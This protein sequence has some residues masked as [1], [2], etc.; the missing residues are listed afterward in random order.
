MSLSIDVNVAPC[1]TPPNYTYNIVM[2][3]SYKA[4]NQLETWDD[5]SAACA[6]E[7]ATLIE[8]YTV[9]DHQVLI[10]MFSKHKPLKGIQKHKIVS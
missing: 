2:D 1:N 4:V 3:I 10:D 6:T 7:G 5:A 9:A 8:Y